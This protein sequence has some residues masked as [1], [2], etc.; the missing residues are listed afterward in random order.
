[1]G[2]RGSNLLTQSFRCAGRLQQRAQADTATEEHQYTPVG[3]TGNF[4]PLRH[5]EYDDGNGGNQGDNGIGVGNT[6]CGFDFGAEYPSDGGCQEN[7][8]RDNAVQSPRDRF[9]FNFH[10]LVQ[11]RFEDDVHGEQH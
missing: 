9:G 10:A 7:Q 8:Q 2:E 1:M 3:I 11:I 6:E 5:A 4:F